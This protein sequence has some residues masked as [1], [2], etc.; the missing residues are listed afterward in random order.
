MLSALG[1]LDAD[2]GLLL[3][4]AAEPVPETDAAAALMLP[5]I[6]ATVMSAIA[7]DS[8]VAT[9][10]QPR[11]LHRRSWQ[12]RGLV[13]AAVVVLAAGVEQVATRQQGAVAA[14][15]QAVPLPF[16]HGT[17]AEAVTFLKHATAA[18][19]ATPV[20]GSGPVRYVKLQQYAPQI[21][22]GHHKVSTTVGTTVTQVWYAPDGST[23]VTE[24]NQEQDLLGGDVGAPTVGHVKLPDTTHWPDPAKGFPTTVAAARKALIDVAQL[25][26]QANAD[27]TLSVEMQDLE[28]LLASGTTNAEQ[29]AAVYG[30]LATTPGSY[31]AGTVTDRLG[32]VGHAIAVPIPGVTEPGNLA[33]LYLIVDA[34][35]GAVMQ[36]EFD[37]LRPPSGLKLPD[38]PYVGDYNLINV[39]RRVAAKGDQ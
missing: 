22:V 5:S 16:A 2:R 23:Q 18:V 20:A 8:P 10:A 27:D 1:P 26:Q 28:S 39:S 24:Q 37:D 32:R 9:V 15:A 7:A 34:R 14:P 38:R 6:K 17:H 21:T 31:D 30:V 4:A 25:G 11:T 35:T 33:T 13:A 29:T 12:V 19:L 36:T 3:L